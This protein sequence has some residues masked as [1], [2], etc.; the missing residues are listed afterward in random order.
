MGTTSEE[1]ADHVINAAKSKLG[2]PAVVGGK[3]QGGIDCFALVDSILKSKSVNAKTAADFGTFTPDADYVWGDAVDLS[4]VKAGDII[5]FR[6]HEI[7]VRTYTLGRTKWELTLTEGPAKRPHHTAIVLEVQQNGSVVVAEQNVRPDAHKVSRDVI[8][9]L[10][11]GMESR[12]VTSTKKLEITVTG[13]AKAYRPV[14][15]N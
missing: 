6:H 4:A 2:G 12:M 8:V 15:K 10:D 14:P 9:R 1:L 7:M 13:V 5:Q 11:S 3:D